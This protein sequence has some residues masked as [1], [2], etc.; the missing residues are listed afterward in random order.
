[1]KVFKSCCE[2]P[3]LPL[4]QTIQY[5]LRVGTICLRIKE[6]NKAIACFEHSLHMRRLMY[7]ENTNHEK[8][9]L[10]LTYLG[11]AWS[12]YDNIHRLEL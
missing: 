8:V 6:A 4:L 1:M 2:L 7:G 3:L 9:L 12:E 5:F 11:V 10:S